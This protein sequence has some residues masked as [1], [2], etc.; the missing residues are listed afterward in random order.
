MG[1]LLALIDDI[2]REW[3]RTASAWDKIVIFYFKIRSKIEL[4][5]GR[6]GIFWARFK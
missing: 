1:D 2:D 3:R 4:N 6:Y 5:F